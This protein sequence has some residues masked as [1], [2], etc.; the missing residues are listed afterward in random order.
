MSVS[1]KLSLSI[2]L[3]SCGSIIFA[4]PAP[5][6]PNAHFHHLHLNATDPAKDIEFYT[7]KFEAEKGKFAGLVDAVW[8]DKAWILF[9]KVNTPPVSDITSTIWHFGWG[10]EDMKATYQKQLDSGTQFQTPITDISDIGG[11]TNM[12]MGRFFYAYVDGP[13]HSLIELNTANHHHF[14]HI[15]LLSEDPVAAGEW[16]AKTFGQKVRSTPAAR[17][18][19]DTQIA[20]SASFTMDDVNFIIYPVQYARTSKWP[21]W[22]GRATFE[23]TQGHVVDHIGIS[24]DNLDDAIAK[25]KAAGVKATDEPR[26][27]A[28]GKIKYAFIEGPDKMRIEIIEGHAKKE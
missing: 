12:T 15:H 3:L 21:Y 7:T 19:R 8:V 24:V 23:S 11:G 26:S 10:A 4:Q 16:Y 6:V 22:D 2:A 25:L 28:G 9:Q 27:V 14:G 20:P 5:T 13:D 17:I 1:R 18:Y